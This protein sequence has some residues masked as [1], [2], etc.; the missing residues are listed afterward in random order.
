[1]DERLE[2][3]LSHMDARLAK[4]LDAIL[5]S[6]VDERSGRGGAAC[7]SL[8]VGCSP[9]FLLLLNLDCNISRSRMPSLL[10]PLV[11]S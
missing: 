4:S 6:Q 1:M 2:Q 10:L 8:V 9:C 7:M 5:S 11:V 3:R